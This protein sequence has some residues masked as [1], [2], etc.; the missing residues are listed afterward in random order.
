M[1]IREDLGA[2]VRSLHVVHLG[3]S[4]GVVLLTAAVFVV[5]ISPLVETLGLLTNNVVV[6]TIVLISV[7]L[8]VTLP[9]LAALYVPLAD[10]QNGFVSVL[11]QSIQALRNQYRPLLVA[12][13]VSVGVA[14]TAG[15]VAI[16][17]WYVLATV[18]RLSQ[19]VLTGSRLSGSMQILFEL[20]VA[21]PLGFWIGLLVTRFADVFVVLGNANPWIAWRSSLSFV[22]R[23]PLSFL[24]YATVTTG[25]IILTNAL[26]LAIRGLELDALFT[27]V[28]AILTV[29][30]CGTLLIAAI[31]VAY[32]QGTVADNAPRFESFRT[33]SWKR[34]VVAVAL[35]SVA[36]AGAG[37]IR[38]ADLG[39]SDE[40]IESLPDDPEKA[41]AAAIEN[42]AAANHRVI[43]HSRNLSAD[44]PFGSMARWEVDY[45]DR[46]YY[47]YLS[48][49]SFSFMGEGVSGR[50]MSGATNE[51]FA[52]VLSSGEW[53]AERIPLGV[54]VLDTDLI[55]NGL[56][57]TTPAPKVVTVNETTIVYR[58]DR[59]EAVESAIRGERSFAGMAGGLTDNSSRVVV[60]DRERG[61]VKEV[62]T[63]YESNETG[64]TFEY[65]FRWEEVG[66]LDLERP[67]GLGPRHPMEWIWDA[68]LY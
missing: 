18:V 35:L 38:V 57:D 52:A 58:H 31:H 59:P 47:A 37:V 25:L 63:L 17:V 44:E 66:T 21:F 5:V 14:L 13:A 54:F 19:Y 12:S 55:D 43:A 60:V 56:P 33:L 68:I 2:A 42:T 1:G 3:I 53:H 26:I 50:Y 62:R 40:A 65:R 7:V 61:V 48:N 41:Y 20:A 28:P 4:L 16:L 23:H 49:F 22:R 45:D 27:Q 30:T 51:S 11:R 39:V 24:G 15:I 36:V 67:D 8:V 10:R 64:R 6:V 9:L 34:I 29:G 32:F 46:Q